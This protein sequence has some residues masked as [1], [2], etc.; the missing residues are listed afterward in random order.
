MQTALTDVV[1]PVAVLAY[2]SG[3]E[4]EVELHALRRPN[5]IRR[6]SG[7]RRPPSAVNPRV[8]VAVTQD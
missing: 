8:T 1:S 2:R 5:R 6:N 7:G 3:R 4:L